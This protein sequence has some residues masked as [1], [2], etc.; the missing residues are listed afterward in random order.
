MK[1]RIADFF[2]Q[3]F[4]NIKTF[5]KWLQPYWKK[6]WH[7]SVF[8]HSRYNELNFFRKLLSIFYTGLIVL[9]FFLFFLETNFL[10]VFGHM[11]GMNEVRNPKIPLITELY[12]ADGK[13]MGKLF[14]E[15]REPVVYKEIHPKTI[16]ALVAT[17]D[18]RFFKHHGFDL[19]AI[20]SAIFSTVKGEARGGSTITQQLVKNIY[21]TR[22][23]SSRGLLGYVPGLRTIIAKIKEWITASKIEFFFTKEEILTQYLN[24]VDFGNN[25]FGIKTAAEYY[26]SK[27]PYKLSLEESA[28]LIGILKGP[29]YYNPRNNP[30]RAK[31]RRNTVLS[32]ME[33]YDF[34]SEKEFKK[35]AKKALK[36]N[37]REIV[38]E[39]GIAPYFRAAVVRE[40]ADWCEKNE[41]NLYTDGL[42][43]YTTINSHVQKYA[44][45]SV[46]ENM[47]H[48]QTAFESGLWGNKYW[49]DYKIAQEKAEQK[50]LTPKPIKKPKKKAPKIPDPPTKTEIH[51]SQLV[52]QS[53]R[54]K[55]YLA[56]GYAPDSAFNEMRKPVRMSILDKGKEKKVRMSPIDSIKHTTQNLHCGV[57][58]I[59]PITGHVIAWVGDLDWTHYKFD[60]VNQS[61]RQPGSTFKP[62]LYATA[63]E[64]G[65]GP[66]DKFKDEPVS[67]PTYEKG[68]KVQ[69]EPRN[70]N[71]TYSYENITLRTALAQSVN[72]VAAQL[73]AKVG[74]K[75]VVQTAKKLGI[76]SKLRETLSIGLGTSS[77]N[78]LELTRA[79]TCFANSGKRPEIV[80]VTK[81]E[82]SKGRQVG[83]FESEA[84]Q[85]I[86]EENAYL[87]TF[88]L[89]GSVE[90]PGGTSRRLYNYGICQGNE[91]GGKTGTSNNYAD[92]W[93]I[94]ITQNLVTGVWVGAND[95]RIHFESAGG[96][97]GRTALPIFG[98][99]MQLVY[100]DKKTG[101]QKGPFIKPV[102]K[103]VKTFDCWNMVVA[104]DSFYNEA[105][106]KILMDSIEK[107][108][109]E[110][111][112]EVPEEPKVPQPESQGQ[113]SENLQ[114]P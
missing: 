33:K 95:M 96:Q 100:N 82:D 59:D 24:V 83:T 74:P 2:I 69:W 89:R 78:L 46:D 19:Y 109:E 71:R 58:S 66:C 34:I 29:S 21:K 68:K 64:Q 35:Y 73:T 50:R 102:N 88:L 37:I 111:N 65:M 16:D 60:H 84:K 23:F 25:S 8:N 105:D 14:V 54:F 18:I 55:T 93:Y 56:N 106:D 42:K 22:D 104:Q 43:I 41:Y 3:L 30:V 94:G 114:K 80:L 112:L 90:E 61:I 99:M 75:K 31:N 27:S 81:I 110:M 38:R 53:E 40:L 51:L 63:L 72:T 26:F 15:E 39:E 32:Q 57:V 62:I 91:I 7:L 36:L 79:Y 98:R 6:I 70:A 12:T 9:L 101:I 49:F 77:V 1:K 28:L 47:K 107:M 103:M 76:K 113:Q 4:E 13:L 45:Q 17:E 85:V 97:G 11:P 86:N 92:G 20:V 87:M 52:V 108:I 10:W 67:I 5:L 48:I 44:E